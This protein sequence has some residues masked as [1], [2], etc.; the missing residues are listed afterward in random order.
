MARLKD[1]WICFASVAVAIRGFPNNRGTILRG[2]GK[3]D[4]SILG[5]IL[6]GS[7][8]FRELACNPYSTLYTV[9]SD[10]FPF[11]FPFDSPLS[12]YTLCR[13][14]LHST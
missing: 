12:L 4:Y 2:P 10:D 1:V 13:L 11:E 8:C 5:S 3:R 7:P 9:A 6:G 14:P